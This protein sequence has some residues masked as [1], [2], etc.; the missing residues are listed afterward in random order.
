MMI[1]HEKL[2]NIAQY[3]NKWKRTHP[4]VVSIPCTSFQRLNLQPQNRLLNQVF[5][6]REIATR[7]FEAQRAPLKRANTNNRLHHIQ[8]F[9]R[10]RRVNMHPFIPHIERGNT[11]ECTASTISIGFAKITAKTVAAAV[12]YIQTFVRH[13]VTVYHAGVTRL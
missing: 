11:T 13:T 3:Q 4:F 1:N 12:L 8:V 2:I 9:G 5:A 7:F 6:P 10:E